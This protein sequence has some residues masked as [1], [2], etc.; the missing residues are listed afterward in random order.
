MADDGGN[1]YSKV[2]NKVISPPSFDAM[3]W[4]N[5]PWPSEQWRVVVFAHGACRLLPLLGGTRRN[6]GAPPPPPLAL[7]KASPLSMLAI[8]SQRRAGL[9]PGGGGAPRPCIPP[10]AREA[11]FR[12]SPAKQDDGVEGL[13]ADPLILQRLR[14]VKKKMQKIEALEL[15]GS[16][17]LNAEQAALVKLKCPR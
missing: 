11:V 13:F 9:P 8:S 14:I 3:S 2:V 7:A 16:H 6:Q 17:E 15:K 4:K 10:L 1:P 5:M 12:L